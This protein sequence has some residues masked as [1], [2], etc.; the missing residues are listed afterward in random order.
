MC[1]AVPPV[2]IAS[3]ALSTGTS[4]VADGDRSSLAW[5]GALNAP[6]E[7]ISAAASRRI[8]PLLR[9]KFA[10]ALSPIMVKVR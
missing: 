4:A 2:I 3:V 8:R 5:A 10:A 6:H 9:Q 7:I 1:M